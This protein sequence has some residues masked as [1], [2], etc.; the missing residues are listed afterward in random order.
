MVICKSPLLASSAHICMMSEHVEDAKLIFSFLRGESST[1]HKAC[2]CFVI[3]L[4][5]QEVCN[6]CSANVGVTILFYLPFSAWKHFRSVIQG[7]QTLTSI[8]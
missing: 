4:I 7:R 2:L 6:L 3:C 5:G 1:K 8:L